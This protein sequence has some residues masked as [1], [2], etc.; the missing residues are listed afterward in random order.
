[1]ERQLRQLIT[2]ASGI[3]VH[4]IRA[5]A[6]TPRPY[7]RLSLITELGDHTMEGRTPLR[8]SMIQV[9]IWAEDMADLLTIKNAVMVLDGYNDQSG[10]DP[11][12]VI[13]LDKVRSGEDTSNPA[14][15]V[16]RYSIDFRVFHS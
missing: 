5:P 3:E 9:D 14:D 13:L 11:I 1:M 10:D 2:D 8:Q 4:W 12:K 16:L 6:N 7:I 15:I